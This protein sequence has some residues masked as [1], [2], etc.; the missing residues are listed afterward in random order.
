MKE[1]KAQA[2]IEYMVLLG[3]M[4]AII[5]GGFKFYLGS[6]RNQANKF[7]TNATIGIMGDV[8]KV[9]AIVGGTPADYP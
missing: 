4:A 5:I 7:F 1:E 8:P 9:R 3:I 2:A 6:S